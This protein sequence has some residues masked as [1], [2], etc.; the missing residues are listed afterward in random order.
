[1]N[2]KDVERLTK[3]SSQNIRFYE[4]AGLIHPV[5]NQEN[6]YRKYEEEDIRRLKLIKMLRMLDMPVEKIRQVLDGEKQLDSSL[7]E[8]KVALEKKIQDAKYAIVMCEKLKKEDNSIEDI[9]VDEYLQDMD[10]EPKHFFNTWISD[11]KDVVHYEQKRSF[12]FTPNREITDRYDFANALY[13]YAREKNVEL[14][15][16]KEGMYPEFTMDGVEYTAERAYACSIYFPV[17]V[18]RCTRKEMLETQEEYRRG[19]KKWIR[20]ARIFLPVILLTLFI[21]FTKNSQLGNFLFSSWDGV[22]IVV[23]L[24][25]IFGVNAIWNYYL[26]WN[27]DHTYEDEK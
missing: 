13:D 9:R 26:Y 7:E 6:R 16:T 24:V 4:K 18:V 1:M 27:R 5:R 11:Y 3:I 21:L 25:V 22:Y 19:R 10:K 8:Q 14:I 15:I 12:T 17:A 20:L 23:A 2:I